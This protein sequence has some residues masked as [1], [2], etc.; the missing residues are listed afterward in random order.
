M[1]P[2]FNHLQE[3]Y[4]LVTNKITS[5]QAQI[6]PDSWTEA[7]SE[8]ETDSHLSSIHNLLFCFASNL[9]TQLSHN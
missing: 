7:I 9:I 6:S 2:Q 5:S 8:H 4:A 3:T 1:L